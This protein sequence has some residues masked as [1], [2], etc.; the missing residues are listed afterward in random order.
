MN[1]WKALTW[2]RKAILIV[3]AVAVAAT[4]FGAFRGAWSEAW[5]SPEAGT[6]VDQVGYTIG[7]S[8][9]DG[10]FNLGIPFAV[11]ILLPVGL[12]VLVVRVVRVVRRRRSA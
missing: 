2:W 7:Y 3:I 4:L 6:G 1:R 10:L 5:N 9:A 11:L 12:I 8:F